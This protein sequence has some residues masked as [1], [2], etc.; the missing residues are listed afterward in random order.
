MYKTFLEAAG[1][2]SAPGPVNVDVEGESSF[3]KPISELENLEEVVHGSFL[4]GA[5]HT[6]QPHNRDFL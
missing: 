6:R 5:K 2:V 3:L 1:E 4:R